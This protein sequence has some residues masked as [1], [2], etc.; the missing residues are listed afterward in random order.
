MTSPTLLFYKCMTPDFLRPMT[1]GVKT[2]GSTDTELNIGSDDFDNEIILRVPL[3]QMGV[4]RDTDDITVAITAATEGPP[5]IVAPWN[6]QRAFSIAPDPLA[7]MVS[8]GIVAVGMQV[9]DP[10]EYHT[11]GPYQGIAGDVGPILKNIKYIGDT[12]EPIANYPRRWPQVFEIQMKPQ[13]FWGSC[14]SAAD[15]G[16]S[17]SARYPY[18]LTIGNGLTLEVYRH[19]NIEEYTINMIE[20]AVYKDNK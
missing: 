4:L 9:R 8:D 6:L 15:E 14:S 16:H 17:F 20:V 12:A 11:I 7:F 1:I 19:R 10:R 5:P 13:S 18:N 3:L 2:D